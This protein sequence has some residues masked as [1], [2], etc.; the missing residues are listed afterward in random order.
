[1]SLE[2]MLQEKG[3]TYEKHSHRATYTAQ[4]LAAEEHVSG[5]D[6]AKPV[7]VK[8]DG[9]YTMCVL[10]ACCHLDLNRVG[11]L[12]G[13]DVRLATEKEMTGL[14]PDC[15]LGAEPPMGPLFG[16]PTI[17]DEALLEDE[18]LTMQSGRHTEALRVRRQDWQDVCDPRMAKISQT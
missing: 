18:F 10:P 4:A 14:F 15:E 3:I 2:E 7:I 5:Y 6:V 11:A 8:G 1:M 9:G 17:A 13:Q 16:M 12:L